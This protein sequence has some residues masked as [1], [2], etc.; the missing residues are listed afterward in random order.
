M[1]KDPLALATIGRQ[2]RLIS[3][4]TRFKV[5]RAY[6]AAGYIPAVE[7][8]TLDDKLRTSARIEDI[9]WLTP[10]VA[11][12]EQF[13]R[14]YGLVSTAD[15]DSHIHAALRSC[16]QTKTFK[17]FYDRKLAELQAARDE[18]VRRYKAAIASGE[19]REPTS[20]EQLAAAANGHSDNLSTQAAM[21]VLAKR[22]ARRAA[23]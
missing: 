20:L 10:A 14:A 6:L 9:Q 8:H 17:R 15:V 7:G 2:F 11:T 19:I 21:R 16:T 1:K 22:A 23:E 12:L 18:T 3:Q 13:A 4:T 5:V